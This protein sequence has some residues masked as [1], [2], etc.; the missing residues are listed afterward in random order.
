MAKWLIVPEAA[1]Y[2]RCGERIIRELM[3]NAQIPHTIFAGKALFS[4]DRLD[5]WL[6]SMERG[7]N[8]GEQRASSET[9]EAPQGDVVPV[10]P[11][12]SH[13]RAADIIEE[14]CS[15]DDK[16]VAGL[17][18]NLKRDL[19][20]SQH[21]SLSPKVYAQLSRHREWAYSTVRTLLRRMVAKGWL[22]YRRVGTSFLYRPA[23]PRENAM[24]RAVREF[25]NRVLDGAM[26]SFVA[27]Y[28]D[29]AG[30][31]SEDLDRLEKIIRRHRKGGGD[32]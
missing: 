32:Q 1:E 27:Y 30:L 31:T 17:G 29:D 9:K 14:L 13:D 11:D 22:D 4:T 28:A 23:V 6:L 10:L 24:R 26:A 2:L 15:Y 3:A 7:P 21:A 25:T 5:E 8:G 20:E 12:Y 19:D 16:F 18:G